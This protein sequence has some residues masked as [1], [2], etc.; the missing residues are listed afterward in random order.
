MF[1]LKG[2]KYCY[3]CLVNLFYMQELIQAVTAFVWRMPH[4]SAN[5]WWGIK[6]LHSITILLCVCVR[7]CVC[8]CVC[9]RT[10]V[11]PV[12]SQKLYTLLE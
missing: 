9:M 4:L 10:C 2:L 11:V 3:T 6:Q 1:P 7:V 12:Q 5:S 8:V